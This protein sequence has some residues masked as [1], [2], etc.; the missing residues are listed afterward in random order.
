[1]A[2]DEIIG[3][4]CFEPQW[5]QNIVREVVQVEGDDGIGPADNRRRQ[6]VPIIGIR[7]IEL[8]DPDNRREPPSQGSLSL[9]RHPLIQ[10]AS[11]SL[12]AARPS[13]DA[14]DRSGDPIRS[15]CPGDFCDRVAQAAGR[16]VETLVTEKI[17]VP[18][19]G[20][21]GVHQVVVRQR[22]VALVKRIEQVPADVGGVGNIRRADLH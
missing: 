18:D 16:H 19:L 14:L 13:R 2:Y 7:Q 3:V 21:P 22:P 10:R 20:L 8:L 1:M 12:A 17:V 9:E 15:G 5:V 6:D 11:P 4:L